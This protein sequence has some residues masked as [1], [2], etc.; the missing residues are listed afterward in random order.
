MLFASTALAVFGL[1][2]MTSAHVVMSVPVPFDLGGPTSQSPLNPDGSNFPCK[3]PG[4]YIKQG[5]STPMALGS[6]QPIAFVG[7]AV[8]GGGSCQV[9]ITYDLEPTKN[10]VWK[11]IHSIQGGCP[12]RNAEGNNGNDANKPSPS[13]YTFPVPDDLPTGE[14]VLAWTWFN[15][16]GNREMY[17]NCA[18]ISITGS[19]KRRDE[20]VLEARNA[21]L[22]ARDL[23]AYNALP[24]MFTANIDNDGCKTTEPL[25]LVFPNPG[26]SV[27]NNGDP[28]DKS[29]FAAPVGSTCKTGN[30]AP[31]QQGNPAP[32]SAPSPSAKPSLPGGVFITVK[33]PGGTAPT[34]APIATQPVAAP[35]V[36]NPPVGNAPVQSPAPIQATTLTVIPTKATAI[37]PPAQTGVSGA[38]SGPCSTEGLWNC[39]GGSS[40]QQCGSGNWSTPQQLAA[41]TKCTPGQS[42][43]ISIQAIAKR[44][45]RFSR[46]HLRRHLQHS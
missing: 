38:L 12:M 43:A 31:P 32:S 46:A 28:T 22:E 35:V 16:I 41:G 11:V 14:A 34:A 30:S 1:A 3:T 44:T 8:H 19:N 24:D 13:Q 33:P 23:S 26:S 10:S 45:P 5:P 25:N 17:M 37:A 40:F 27:E 20:D 36:S 21:T 4:R 39:I 6:T 18:P 9:S 7:S 42:E 15:R 29:K 2:S